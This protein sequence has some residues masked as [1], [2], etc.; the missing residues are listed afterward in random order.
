VALYPNRAK[1]KVRKEHYVLAELHRLVPELLD[2]AETVVWDCPFP[3]GCSLKQPDHLFAWPERYLEIE[4]GE[5]GIAGCECD[6]EDSRSEVVAAD[7]G[8]PGLVVRIDPDFNGQV[9]CRKVHL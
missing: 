9:C 3:G 7:L 4:V 6:E 5:E 2:S 1:M 8:R